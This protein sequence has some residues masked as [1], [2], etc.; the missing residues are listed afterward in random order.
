MKLADSPE[1]AK[2]RA[3][4]RDFLASELPDS[5]RRRAAA[6][7]AEAANE[8]PAAPST[9]PRAGGTG[10]RL[11]GGPMGEWRGKLAARGWIAPAWPK[12][13]GGAGLSTME[14]FILNEE[15]AVAGAPQVGGM[16][17][18]M[19]GPTLITHGTDAQKAEHQIGRAHV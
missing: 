8:Q 5:V 9:G 16:G 19:V 4:V 11:E 13:Y 12:E 14:Q 2:W 17:V 6:P 3:D 18:S 7:F 10:F 1:E 15:F